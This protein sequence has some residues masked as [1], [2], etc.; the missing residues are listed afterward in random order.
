MAIQQ[1]PLACRIEMLQGSSIDATIVDKVKKL[2]KPNDKV[3]VILDSNHTHDHVLKELEYYSPLVTKDNYL[4]VMDTIVDHMPDN[5]YPDRP[6]GKGN[7]PKT[8]THEFLKKTDRFQIDS[9]IQN[10]LLITV[11]VDGYLQCIK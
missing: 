10:K 2:I 8:A 11:A 7:N 4:V 5:Y 6:W 3:M 1:H 9:A